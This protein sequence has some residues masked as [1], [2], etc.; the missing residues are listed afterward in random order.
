MKNVII[1]LTP[2]QAVAL[3]QALTVGIEGLDTEDPLYTPLTECMVAVYAV[4]GEGTEAHH[5]ASVDHAVN[6]HYHRLGE[7]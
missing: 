1:E 6:F 7:D 5:Q 4:A 3:L 2:Q